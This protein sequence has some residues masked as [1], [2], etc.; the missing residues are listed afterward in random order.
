MPLPSLGPL[1]RPLSALVFNFSQ[2]TSRAS[3]HPC[4]AA[5]LSCILPRFT[6]A[7]PI[8]V[9]VLVSPSNYLSLKEAYTQIPG[10]EVRPLLIRPA[11]L[12]IASM[13][14]LM[15]V[16][17]SS[18]PPLYMS[19]VT[20]ILRD[21]ARAS[22]NF[23]FLEFKQQIKELDILPLQRKPLEQR[24]DLLESFLDL[25]PYPQETFSP[26]LGNMTIVDLSCPFV[27]ENTACVL[28]NICLNLFMSDSTPGVG[29]V[30][31]VDEAHKVC[32]PPCS[33]LRKSTPYIDAKPVIVSDQHS[34]LPHL[35]SLTHAADPSATALRCTSN[36]RYSGTNYRPPP[37]RAVLRNPNPPLQ[38][39]R[40][41]R[42]VEKAPQPGDAR[43]RDFREDREPVRGRRASFRS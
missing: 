19:H 7:R 42:G 43:R 28:F 38:L 34:C 37:P 36:Y 16:D 10:V 1:T 3:F 22:S 29:K 21:M 26:S 4:E 11:D 5:F 24:M 13:L 2:Y 35:H 30:L 18:Q 25:S 40:V 20:K 31:A 9:T 27:D 33:R 8:A 23:D 32:S 17:Q 6:I 41:V 39:P 12:N 15:A 14:T